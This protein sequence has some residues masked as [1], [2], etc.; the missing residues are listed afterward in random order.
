MALD[1]CRSATFHGRCDLSPLDL[2]GRERGGHGL[3]PEHEA[4]VRIGGCPDRV[5]LVVGDPLDEAKVLRSGR[6][7]FTVIV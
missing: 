3:M 5:H 1:K 7:T 4:E 2:A 6:D